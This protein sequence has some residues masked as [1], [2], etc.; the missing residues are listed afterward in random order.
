M[1]Q[2]L[3]QWEQG[4][5]AP[6]LFLFYKLKT[7]D[8]NRKLLILIENSLFT[9]KIADSNRKFMILTENGLF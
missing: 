6:Q 5:I 8:S 9:L 3:T 1:Q 4:M 7:A 2:I